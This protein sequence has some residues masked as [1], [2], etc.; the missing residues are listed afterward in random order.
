MSTSSKLPGSQGS[1]RLTRSVFFPPSHPSC[2]CEG[3]GSDHLQTHLFSP[4]TELIL[5]YNNMSSSSFYILCHMG[6]SNFERGFRFYT[7][8]LKSTCGSNCY[9]QGDCY[10]PLP[11]SIFL[12]SVLF[13]QGRFCFQLNPIT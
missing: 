8:I 7:V 12:R 11:V 9:D 10:H 5:I 4:D 13:L 2:D 3:K 6:L 1:T